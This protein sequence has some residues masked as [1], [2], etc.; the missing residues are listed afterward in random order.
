MKTDL[1]DVLEAAD[2]W[3]R[4]TA[5]RALSHLAS[6]GR[7][8]T[9][10]DITDLGVPDPDHPNRWGALFST[11]RTRGEIEPLGWTYSRRPSRSFGVCRVWIGT[12]HRKGSEA[13]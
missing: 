3:W 7:A 11:A 6:T 2:D 13:A 1:E 8:F 4:D 5:E 10:M 9:A 12:E